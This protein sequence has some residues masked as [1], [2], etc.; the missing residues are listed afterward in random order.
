MSENS[1]TPLRQYK[2]Y[3]K[4]QRQNVVDFDTLISKLLKKYPEA[5]SKEP[6]LINVI[7][8]DELTEY[9]EILVE[10]SKIDRYFL[11]ATL[12]NIKTINTKIKIRIKEGGYK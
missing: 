12:A 9:Q 10:Q 7:T 1:L 5:K 6:K 3:L 8:A 11:D 2:Y 4:L